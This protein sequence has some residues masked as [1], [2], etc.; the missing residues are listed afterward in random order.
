MNMSLQLIKKGGNIV[1]LGT[2]SKNVKFNYQSIINKEINL[3]GSLCYGT[4]K[5][6]YEIEIALKTLLNKKFYCS[7]L[8]SHKISFN[9]AAKAFKIASNKKYKSIKVQLEF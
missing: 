1:C 4:F 8:I 5:G 2:T 9:K 6:N 7:D 3:I